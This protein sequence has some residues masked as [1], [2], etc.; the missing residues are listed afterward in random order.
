MFIRALIASLLVVAAAVCV[1]QPVAAQDFGGLL[2]SLTK[3]DKDRKSQPQ[4]EQ[5]AKE[6]SDEELQQKLTS[7]I[8]AFYEAAPPTSPMAG[9]Q[10]VCL[11]KSMKVAQDVRSS[12]GPSLMQWCLST[13][14][15]EKTVQEI[16]TAQKQKEV[17]VKDS[18]ETAS[19][20]ACVSRTQSSASEGDVIYA[21]AKCDGV[22]ER[23]AFM[24]RALLP[25]T[26]EMY[27]ALAG[28]QSGAVFKGLQIGA[29]FKAK[30]MPNA[31]GDGV[32]FWNGSQHVEYGVCANGQCF[33]ERRD[34]TKI[35]WKCSTELWSSFASCTTVDTPG[36]FAT[37]FGAK[38]EKLEIGLIAPRPLNSL[39]G[40]DVGAIQWRIVSI[41]LTSED[42]SMLQ[43]AKD[44][45]QSMTKKAPQ[46]QG[47][48]SRP[49]DTGLTPPKERCAAVMKKRV[50]DLT[51]ADLELKKQCN[52]GLTT[53]ADLEVQQTTFKYGDCC[54][55]RVVNSNVAEPFV[56]MSFVGHEALTV[57]TSEKAKAR[58]ANAE[59]ELQ[60][61]DAK[62]RGNDF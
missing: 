41:E 17:Q 7:E 19:F 53:L 52:S 54:S 11:E 49:L 39:A 20:K 35:R 10:Q 55:V 1:T 13:K 51:S 42:A 31:Q 61:Q 5:K 8:R 46:G 47:S 34:L 2:K 27:A 43:P 24:I 21:E 36:K 28:T 56:V 57:V 22:N 23:G 16:G 3:S 25:N 12:K 32:Y 50:T 6:F 44:Y 18:A 60:A 4:Q 58:R 37:A 30:D 48:Q 38:L 45:L 9:P 14:L 29:E 15:A 26:Q 59:K 40:R 62:R 33:A